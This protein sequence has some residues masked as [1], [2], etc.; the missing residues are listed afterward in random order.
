MG[1]LA[2]GSGIILVVGPQ[3][4]RLRVHSLF[5]R[6][7]SNVFQAMFEHGWSEGHDLS[8]EHP[9]EIPLE[10]DDTEVMKTVCCAI[11]HRN[12]MLPTTIPPRRCP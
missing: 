9:K 8:R 6:S 4:V 2:I 1:S 5:L 11:H 12:D 7:A 3:A 10:K